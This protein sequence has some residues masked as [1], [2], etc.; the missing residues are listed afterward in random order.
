MDGNGLI[1]HTELRSVL[2]DREVTLTIKD[3]KVEEMIKEV[4][5]NGDGYIDYQEFLQMMAGG[6]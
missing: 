3:Q 5:R 6:S 4:D 1:T 2:R